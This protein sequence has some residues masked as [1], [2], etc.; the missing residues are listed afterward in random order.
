[1]YEHI[2]EVGRWECLICHDTPSLIKICSATRMLRGETERQATVLST[3]DTETCRGFVVISRVCG[4]WSAEAHERGWECRQLYC[5]PQ[6]NRVLQTEGIA[7]DH[8][9][10]SPHPLLPG[11]QFVLTCI[12]TQISPNLFLFFAV[13]F[14]K[15]ENQIRPKL[16]T[17][18]DFP[19]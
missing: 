18:R 14:W 15:T 16:H 1:M 7:E 5:R 9:Q 6:A 8:S 10:V 2:Y 12:T 11:V 13:Y 4:R 17:N 19:L 3:R